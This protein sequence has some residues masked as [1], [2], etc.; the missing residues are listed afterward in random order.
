MKMGIV[1][2]VLTTSHILLLNGIMSF[3]M[4]MTKCTLH[5]AILTLSAI[6]KISFLRLKVMQILEEYVKDPLYA[7]P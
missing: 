6:S 3:C 2:V 7:E 1:R 5:I 4:I